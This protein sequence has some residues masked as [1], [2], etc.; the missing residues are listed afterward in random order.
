MTH[1]HIIK[2]YDELAYTKGRK[3]V[4]DIMEVGYG[5][6]ET[7]SVVYKNVQVEGRTL[8]IQNKKFDID[9]YEH[10]YIVGFG[11]VVCEAALALEN[12]LQE[13]I[14]GGAVI[15]LKSGVCNIIDDYAGTHPIPSSENFD[16][17][18]HIIE[19]SK[20]ATE[21]DLVI[22]IV[23]GGG[24]ALLCSS[25]EECDQGQKLYNNFLK[26]GGTIEE[27]NVL[28]KHIS[29]LK[30]GGLATVLYPATV[31]GLVFSDVPGGD[32]SVVASGPT[33]KDTT[34]I[35]YARD[36]IRKYNIDEYELNE[37]P[38]D[39]K[40]FEKI[41]NFLMLS[42]TDAL[43]AMSDRAQQLGYQVVVAG[44]AL[45][46]DA[47]EISDIFYQISSPRTVVLAGGEM[48]VLVPEGCHGRG[49][50][51]DYLALCM[52]ER[53]KEGQCFASFASDGHDNTDASGA[54]VDS[55]TT[56]ALTK[57][58]IDVHQYKVCM[59]SYS[60]MKDLNALIYTGYLESNVSDLMILL[61]E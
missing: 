55:N 60:A 29:S 43:R 45:Y 56:H 25:Q 27:L 34:T 54:I 23:S 58:T 32:S 61:N 11:K 7:Q 48:K 12:I 21:R 57:L 10:I 28:R 52:L 6:I 20:N 38:K 30:G 24:S 4:L 36:I 16:A 41:H 33:Y 44:D 31:I 2:N 40:Y 26:T 53:I 42:N 50:R 13:K 19:V 17:T 49:G 15:G 35:E 22:V 46:G 51:N 59:D 3:D 9:A 37:T 18:K 39:D 1:K 47:Q 5:S 14:S 8:I